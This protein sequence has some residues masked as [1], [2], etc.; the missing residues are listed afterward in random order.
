MEV[1]VFNSFDFNLKYI[2]LPA[3][4]IVIGIIIYYII[5]KILTANIHKKV[6]KKRHQEKRITT[7]NTLLLNIIKYII[8]I[9]VL[10]A[11]LTVFNV[12]I[13]SILAG[14]GISA[15]IAGLALQDILKDLLAGMVIITEDQFEIGDIVK[16]GDFLGEVT[17]ISLR[18]TRV[19]DYQGVT[20]IFANHTIT[21]VTNYSLDDYLCVIDIA[22]DYNAKSDKV[23]KVLEDLG[24]DL[25]NKIEDIKQPIEVWGVQDLSDSAVIYR[26]CA[27]TSSKKRNEVTRKI[28]KEIKDR[29]EKEK[30]KIPYKQI[31]VHN[32][33]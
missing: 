26:L 20:K 11:I 3:I 7:I 9:F 23:L 14:V 12:N 16:I 25:E 19:K 29:L 28:K 2:L 6:I 27:L 10:I 30:I 4:Y 8:V 17:S 32:G 24:K 22:V 18:T 5:K 31:E 21:S 33:K 1:K 15:A 13:T